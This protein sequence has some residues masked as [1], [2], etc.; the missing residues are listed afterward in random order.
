MMP[1]T[2]EWKCP[3]CGKEFGSASS[4]PDASRGA[5]MVAHRK[6]HQRQGQPSEGI[7]EAEGRLIPRVKYTG[8]LRI[9]ELILTCHVLEDG[10]RVIPE[11]DI[12]RA[13]KWL[14]IE[15]DDIETLFLTRAMKQ[16]EEAKAK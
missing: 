10:R 2:W 14:G 16:V 4:S 6:W 7:V 9:G 1:T 3:D 12:L 15:D 11:T 13:L 5:A 8:T